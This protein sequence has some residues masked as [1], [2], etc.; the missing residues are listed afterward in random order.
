MACRKNAEW[1]RLERNISCTR[2][3]STWSYAWT[4]GCAAKA[5]G[6]IGRRHIR[7]RS[8]PLAE[9]VAKIVDSLPARRLVSVAMRCAPN[10]GA[11]FDGRLQ[12]VPGCAARHE[13]GPEHVSRLRPQLTRKAE[14]RIKLREL[15]VRERPGLPKCPLFRQAAAL[16]TV[17]KG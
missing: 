17:L 16:D 14:K 2:R 3:S 10:V 9:D 7:R 5:A 12:I 6:S 4:S 13:V 15:A 11:A 8:R 1:E